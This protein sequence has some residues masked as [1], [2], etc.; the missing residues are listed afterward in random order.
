MAAWTGL[1]LA[2]AP[3][4]SD[5]LGSRLPTYLHPLAGRPLA[6]H[7][8]RAVADVAPAPTSV[9]AGPELE[10]QLFADLPGVQV[11]DAAHGVAWALEGARGR[12][13]AVDALAPT[14]GRAL[15]ALLEQRGDA[16]LEGSDGAI[17]AAWL[18]HKSAARLAVLDGDLAALAAALPEA[19]RVTDPGVFTVRSR[20]CLARASV[21]IRDRVVERLMGEG[22]TF[23]LPS[24]VMV[25]V[26]VSIGRDTVVYPGAVI[27]GDT[28]I[29][30]EAVIG[31][32]CRIIA[33][34]IGSGVELKGFNYLSH[35]SIR[36][37]AILEAYV[38]RGYDE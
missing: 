10:P 36:N 31:P 18:G 29:G 26:G 19:R 34:R 37:R 13:L 23:L 25:D 2:L 27:E 7:A 32:C 21:E 17:V 30:E 35:T 15:P 24:S 4:G 16:L 22:V 5:T 11:V 1:V 9:V 38:R 14:A 6:W 12:V 20:A 8:A 33:S 28:T 3:P